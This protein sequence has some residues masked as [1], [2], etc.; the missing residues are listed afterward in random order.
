MR[1]SFA[2]VLLLTGCSY[3]KEAV[4]YQPYASC[5]ISERDPSFF[6]SIVVVS[7]LKTNPDAQIFVSSGTSLASA[8]VQAAQVAAAV[9]PKMEKAPEPTPRKSI[10][11]DED[12]FATSAIDKFVKRVDGS[13]FSITIDGLT[14]PVIVQYHAPETPR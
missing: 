11:F 13:Q 3:T 10:F 9:T 2:L 12:A 14:K 7:C 1:R 4:V 5:A 6:N 8:A